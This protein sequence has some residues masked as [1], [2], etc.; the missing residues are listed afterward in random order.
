MI[1]MGNPVALHSFKKT[2]RVTPS[3]PKRGKQHVGSILLPPLLLRC[4]INLLIIVALWGD[5]ESGGGGS[6][7]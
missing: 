2:M 4:F 6:T 7:M 3:L 1:F 5:D